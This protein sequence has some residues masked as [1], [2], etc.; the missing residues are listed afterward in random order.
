MGAHNKGAWPDLGG[1]RSVPEEGV[2]RLSSEGRAGGSKVKR[3]GSVDSG[4]VP[5]RGNRMGEG[6]PRSRE[7][8]ECKEPSKGQCGA[9]QKAR[10]RRG[11]VHRQAQLVGHHPALDRSGTAERGTQA[12]DGRAFQGVTCPFWKWDP[13]DLRAIFACCGLTSGGCGNEPGPAAC[14][15]RPISGSLSA[16]HSSI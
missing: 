11:Q 9:A 4:R 16:F 5:G 12:T 7:L 3:V 2:F 8:G 10:W 13:W 1:H 6:S 14:R 15:L